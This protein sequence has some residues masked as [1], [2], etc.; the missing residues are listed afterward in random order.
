M[1]H[2]TVGLAGAVLAGCLAVGACTAVSKASTASIPSLPGGVLFAE[3]V[4]EREDVVLGIYQVHLVN[5]TSGLVD[6]A[7]VQISWP[8][9]NAAPASKT[10]T[11]IAVHAIVD[12]PVPFAGA[13]CVG[14][15]SAASMP[16]ASLASATVHFVDGTSA[17]IPVIDTERLLSK[18]YLA[19]CE[20]QNID[21]AVHVSFR[22]IEDVTIDGLPRTKATI[23][24]ER[25]AAKGVIR[26][27][28]LKGTVVFGLAPESSG[29]TGD[30][31]PVL[32]MPA[33]QTAA[34]V[35]VVISEAGCADHIFAETKQ[36]FLFVVSL[37]PG[38]GR[39]H[40]YILAPDVTVQPHLLQRDI[41]AC[42][43]KNAAILAPPAASIP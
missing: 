35:G 27:L 25:A 14:D 3:L 40:G 7:N 26:I 2:D 18:L 19:D 28:D 33:W 43:L 29:A 34:D 16:G 5:G 12:L 22:A 31:S 30:S 42:H 23:H 6:I 13:R 4:Q 15:G 32:T 21:K 39:P 1:R 17:A 37:D 11:K 24:V 41:E 9:F 8:G 38:D 20:R 36:P 10:G